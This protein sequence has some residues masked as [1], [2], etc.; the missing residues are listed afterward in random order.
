MTDVLFYHLTESKLEDALPPLID[1][2][3][4]RGWQVAVQM[5][6]PARRD[7]L[8]SHLWT[9]R[10]DSF[11]PHGT[12]EDEM[13]SRQPVLLTISPDNINDATVRFFIDGAE[14]TD[15][16]AYQRVVLM[17]DGYDQEQ[18]ESA[19]AQWK[20]LK[21]EGHNLTYWQQTQDGR[22]EKKA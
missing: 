11:L 4:E 18:L 20:R 19:R 10:E 8:D 7:L 15:V 9:Y 1:K 17:F 16:G 13:A 14:V 21:G 22:W 2:S 3:V 5:R 12:D 6:E